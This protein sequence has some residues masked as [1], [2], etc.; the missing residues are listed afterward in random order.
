MGYYTDTPQQ[1]AEKDEIVFSEQKGTRYKKMQ[2]VGDNNVPRK[3]QSNNAAMSVQSG[4]YGDVVLTYT[5]TIKYQCSSKATEWGCYNITSAMLICSLT[6]NHK[7]VVIQ[8][9][10]LTLLW[11]DFNDVSMP[12]LHTH[13]HNHIPVVDQCWRILWEFHPTGSI[14]VFP[15]HWYVKVISITNVDQQD[16]YIW[17]EITIQ[18]GRRG[19]SWKWDRTEIGPWENRHWM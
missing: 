4:W 13:T 9:R 2:K 12:R 11:L 6:H 10:W 16:E 17:L 1:Y 5:H 15:L 7:P 19:N 8:N 14:Q 18:Y 3:L